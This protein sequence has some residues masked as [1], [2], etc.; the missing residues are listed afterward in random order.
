[1]SYKRSSSLD[2]L[3]GGL[4][5]ASSVE[6]LALDE[7]GEEVEVDRKAVAKASAKARYHNHHHH[8]HHLHQ[9]L[10]IQIVYRPMRYTN[11]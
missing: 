5:R 2:R 9:H 6:R 3:R 10:L 11:A 1:M 8:H 4:A 7:D